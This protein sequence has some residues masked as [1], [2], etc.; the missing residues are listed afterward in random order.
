MRWKHVGHSTATSIDKNLK[1][2][3]N[4]FWKLKKS[5]LLIIPRNLFNWL[6]S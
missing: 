4:I 5:I 6:I 3:Q 1:H 2:K